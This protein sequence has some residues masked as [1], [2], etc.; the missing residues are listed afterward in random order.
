MAFGVEVTHIASVGQGSATHGPGDAARHVERK[1][2]RAGRTWIPADIAQVFLPALLVLRVAHAERAL[3]G[4]GEAVVD[5]SEPGE[6]L[7][8]DVRVSERVIA[9]R[10][11]G[12]SR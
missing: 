8:R 5:L 9:I 7:G 11:R 2:V 3:E 4:I 10:I 6:R 1:G 12:R